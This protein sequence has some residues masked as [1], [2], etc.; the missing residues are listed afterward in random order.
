MGEQAETTGSGDARTGSAGAALGIY[1]KSQS[2]LNGIKDITSDG[3]ESAKHSPGSTIDPDTGE[4]LNPPYDPAQALLER[5]AAQ[6]VARSILP[7]SQTAK[8]LRVSRLAGGGVEVW[9]SPDHASAAFGGL[10]TCHSVWACPVC[11]AKITER[12]RAEVSAAMD[13]WKAQGGSVALLTL[14]HPHTRADPLA[15]L[16]AAEQKAL[17]SFFAVRAVKDLLRSIG[18]V[19]QIRAWEVTQ[20]RKREI[21]NGWH[22]HFHILLF[23]ERELSPLELNQVE[24]ELYRAWSGACRRA[25]LDSPSRVH[26]V[27][28]DDGSKAAAYVTKWGMD[29]ELTKGHSKRAKDGETPFDLLRSVLADPA[30][31]Q[32]RALFAEFAKAFRG[33]RQLVW[34]RGLRELLELGAE[35]SDAEVAAA[36]MEDCLLLARLSADDWRL[37][38]GLDA[39]GELL[40]IAKHG[41]ELVLTRFLETLKRRWNDEQTTVQN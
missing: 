35:A 15:D 14:T 37:V 10:V 27:R 20:G 28:L 5:Y 23:L 39:R 7:N 9:Y 13:A 30:D 18:R 33:K 17:A 36:R 6:S 11:A 21:N 2:T 32:G 31:R 1:G 22:P 29:R 25:G 19:G 4:V 40:V 38:D 3:T 16:L 12:R 26:G 34:S 24:T 8:C 41:S